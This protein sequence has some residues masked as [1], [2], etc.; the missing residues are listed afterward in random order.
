M[1]EQ[2]KSFDQEHLWHPYSPMQGAIPAEPVVDAK[3]LYITLADGRVLLDGVGSWWAVIH[4]YNNPTINRAISEQMKHFSHVMFGGFTHRPAIELGERL[5]ELLPEGLDKIFYADSG[6]IACEVAI[7]MAIQYQFACGHKGKSKM[8]TVKGGYHGD[9]LGTMALCDPD[10]GMHTLFS[11]VIAR[12]FFGPKPPMGFDRPFQPGDIAEV[13]RIL[14]EHHDEIAGV[15]LE[16]ILQGASGMRIYSPEYLRQLQRL[17]KEYGVLLILDEIATGFGRTGKTWAMEHAGIVPDIVCVGKALTGGH[18][19]L[20]ATITNEEISGAISREGVFMHGPTFMGNALSCAAACGAC[21]VFRTAN[22][23]PRVKAIEGQLSRE[24]LP[25]RERDDVVED[26]RVLG[27]LGVV[28]A[29]KQWDRKR[30]QGRLMEHGIWARPFG[31]LLYL[32]PS[33]T[34]TSDE[35]RKMTDAVADCVASPELLT[36]FDLLGLDS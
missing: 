12:H 22:V 19:P 15:M 18:L 26:V 29:K 36:D 17:C 14:A 28:E 32:M 9:T 4:G 21:E 8:M 3:G 6:S 31:N 24:M 35:I 27:T 30:T 10:D 5:I 2:W 11:G 25:L 23:L 13:E 16:P 1:W 20:A 34:A 33:Y 7:K